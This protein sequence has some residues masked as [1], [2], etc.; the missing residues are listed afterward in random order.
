[1]F[2][3]NAVK[4]YHARM[5]TCDLCLAD[6]YPPQGGDALI[7]IDDLLQVTQ[8]WGRLGRVTGDA[9]HNGIVNVDDLLAVIN[10]W[11]PCN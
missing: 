3:N 7:N 2:I 8:D 4:G 11:G 5:R 6:T 9:N 1:M 10:A